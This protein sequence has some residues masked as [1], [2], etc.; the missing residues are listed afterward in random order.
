VNVTSDAGQ[1]GSRL[2]VYLVFGLR[3]RSDRWP[4]ADACCWQSRELWKLYATEACLFLL[5]L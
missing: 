5:I 4:C 2:A 1:I 3:R